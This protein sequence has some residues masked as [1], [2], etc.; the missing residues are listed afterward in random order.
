[1][2]RPRLLKRGTVGVSVF[3][4]QYIHVPI[5]ILCHWEQSCH[6]CSVFSQILISSRCPA[7]SCS[8]WWTGPAGAWL[9]FV[10]GYVC[11]I[12][13]LRCRLSKH[14]LESDGASAFL[15]DRPLLGFCGIPV[16]VWSCWTES[17]SKEQS[18]ENTVVKFLW[19]ILHH[20]KEQFSQK[21]KLEVVLNSCDFIC[22]VDQVAVSM[23]WPQAVK[24]QKG[25]KAPFKSGLLMS[26][27]G[28]VCGSDW[29]VIHQKSCPLLQPFSFI[30]SISVC[31]LYTTIFMTTLIR[32]LWLVE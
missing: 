32:R 1:M 4:C 31:F 22:Y 30:R 13:W 7:S 18:R 2:S 14:E 9:L 29:N 23:Q 20:L 17:S 8:T 15:F 11:V 10:C 6:N 27:D 28:F 21:W 5:R 24:L 16:K 25:Q 19:K 26:H 12:I 3:A